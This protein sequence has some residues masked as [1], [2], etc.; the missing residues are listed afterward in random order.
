MR[1]TQERV[2]SINNKVAG[3]AYGIAKYK[4]E[5]IVKKTEDLLKPVATP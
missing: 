1:D 5:A 4:Y 2:E 3:W